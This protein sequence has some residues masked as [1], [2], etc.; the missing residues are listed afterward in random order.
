VSVLQLKSFRSKLIPRSGKVAFFVILVL[1]SLTPYIWLISTAVKP[2]SEVV[3]FPPK[4]IPRQPTF[5]NFIK[6]FETAPFLRFLLNSSIVSITATLS[7][8]LF[9]SMAGYAFAKLRFPAKN[10]LFIIVVATMMVPWQITIIPLF[11]LIVKFRWLNSYKALIIPKMVAG[12]AVFL[13]RQ[14]I[15]GVPD[16]LMDASRIDG[17]GYFRIY[18]SI[19]LPNIKPAL[20]ALAIFKFLSMWND[21]LWPVIV[22]KTPLMRTLPLGVALFF[23]EESRSPS[24]YNLIMA[25]STLALLPTVVLFVSLQKHFIRGVVL[26]GLKG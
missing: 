19:I 7:A 18:R 10:L 13:M 11:N 17:C 21:Y 14:F 4:L 6:V 15:A 8:L 23:T 22:V 16:E 1:F 20:A 25:A 24:F 2:A 26:S 12:F 3:A 5:R 9:G